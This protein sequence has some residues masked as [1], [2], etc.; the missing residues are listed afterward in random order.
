MHTSA[1]QEVVV[2]CADPEALARFWASILECRWGMLDADWAVVDADPVI[3]CFQKVPEAKASPKNRLHLDIETQDAAA[4]VDR[5]SALG[6]HVLSDLRMEG[7]SG[8]QVLQD[9]EGNEFC[10]VTDPSGSWSKTLR[11]RATREP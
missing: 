9:P 6:A 5:A 7:D 4:A 11:S 1:I 2:D 8:Y 3:L 10:F